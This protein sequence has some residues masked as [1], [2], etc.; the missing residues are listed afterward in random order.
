[1][2]TAT[3][4]ATLTRVLRALLPRSRLL[5][6]LLV[7]GC[8]RDPAMPA[9]STVAA[10]ASASAPRSA[11]PR[12]EAAG[13]EALAAPLPDVAPAPRGDA[14]RADDAAAV[15]AALT[16]W[17]Q[18][19]GD[20]LPEADVVFV[21]RSLSAFFPVTLRRLDR[22]PLPDSTRNAARTRYR[23]E[24][25][26]ELLAERLPPGGGHI[27]GLTGVDISTTKGNVADWGI[28]GLA[29]L[30]GSAC[31]ISKFRTG[32]GTTTPE[33]ARVRLGKVAVH[34]I[35]HTL[36][37]EHCPT[38]G[39]LMEDAR[40]TVLTCDREHDLCPRCRA[41]LAARGYAVLAPG[42]ALPWP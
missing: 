35:G 37:L 28:L 32:R 34:E 26:L 41:L 19:L 39:C 4:R 21:E 11:P 3:A 8:A 31:V 40:G 24:K 17:L 5:V 29:T 22:I 25:L 27:L 16:I 15:P 18:P 20:G 30:D 42:A 7:V 13:D 12:S 14:D 38:Q 2:R 10:G 33:Q 9:A 6:P 23:A 1:V 36:G